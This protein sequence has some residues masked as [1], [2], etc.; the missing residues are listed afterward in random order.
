MSETTKPTSP[1]AK[2]L[3]FLIGLAF[4]GGAAGAGFLVYNQQQQRAFEAQVAELQ[5]KA[6]AQMPGKLLDAAI[7]ELGGNLGGLGLGGNPQIAPRVVAPAAAPVVVSE[8]VKVNEIGKGFVADLENNR[9]AA[10]YRSMSDGFQKKTERKDFDA[11]VAKFPGLRRLSAFSREQ[12]TRKNND[13]SW[14]FYFTSQDTQGFVGKNLVNLALT[15]AKDGDE[16]RI[17]ELEIT[18]EK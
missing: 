5:V 4:G 9:V 1:A 18:A 3:F 8:E 13:K 16:W 14:E 11:L 10:A 6:A 2:I 12:K 7:N 15:I 17:D